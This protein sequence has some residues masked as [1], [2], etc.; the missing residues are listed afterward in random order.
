MADVVSPHP[1]RPRRRAWVQRLRWTAVV[2]LVV[3][4]GVR[5]VTRWSAA[6]RV[7][8]VEV[9]RHVSG[10]ATAMPAAAFTVMTVNLAHGR[11]AGFS[12][13]TTSRRRLRANLADAAALIHRQE[14]DAVCL[15]E[16]D[17]P[18]WWSGGFDH[19]AAV[20]RDAEMP[21]AVR[22]SHV[23][24]VGL[25]YGTAVLSRWG[26]ADAEAR[27]FT[28]SPPTFAKGFTVAAVTW[29]GRELVFDL[30]SVHTDFASARVRRR[31]VEEL[32]A[33]IEARDRPVVIAGDLNNGWTARGSTRYLAERLALSAWRPEAELVTFPTTG[34][35]LDWILVSSP[36]HI[37]ECRVLEEVVSDH[38]ALVATVVLHD[39]HATTRP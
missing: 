6:E 4:L 20:A 3:L 38:R 26:L 37:V 36:F 24:G 14:P 35:R 18:S 34:G 11:A 13:L 21:L 27:T 30:V 33:V 31:Q 17:S 28:P 39:D 29:P 25:H 9:E 8:P 10:V 16:A 32:V 2:V 22:A 23:D 12:Q 7:V 5:L 15:Q 1:T 19:V